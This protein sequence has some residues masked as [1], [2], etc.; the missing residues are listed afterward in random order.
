LKGARIAANDGL[1][2]RGYRVQQSRFSKVTAQ[3]MVIGISLAFIINFGP[4]AGTAC[5]PQ[6]GPAATGD[7]LKISAGEFDRYYRQRLEQERE[8]R[9][10]F[11]DTKAKAEGFP[12]QVAQ[13]M[14]GNR[15]LA[16]EAGKRGLHMSD[17]RLRGMIKYW[18]RNSMPTT[19]WDQAAYERIIQGN[20]G[21]TPSEWEDTLRREDAAAQ[22]QALLGLTSMPT[23]AQMR[24]RFNIDRTRS[25]FTAV[26]IDRS[27]FADQVVKA[28]EAEVATWAKDDKNK[29]AIAK[30]YEEQK[31]RFDTPKQVRARHILA[32]FK[33][34]NAEAQKKAKAKI[35]KA[36]AKIEAGDDFAE[37]AKAY[38]EDGASK[39]GDLGFFGP[40]RMVK[41]FEEAAF[42]LKA[43]EVSDLVTSPF[44]YHIIK[45][46]EIK[47]AAVKS[48]EDVTPELAQEL[49]KKEKTSGLTKAHAAAILAVMQSGVS[50]KKLFAAGPEGDE[51]R[52]KAG[53]ENTLKLR[54]E[55]TGWVTAKSRQIKGIGLV[56]GM[57]SGLVK[58]EKTGPC[59]S[60][61]PTETGFALCALEERETPDD[62]A[63]EETSEQLRLYLGYKLRERLLTELKANLQEAKNTQIHTQGI[64]GKRY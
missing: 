28:E 35:D 37:V 27:A 38:S 43:G 22:I 33:K 64:E 21:V 6:S 39:G 49:L 13:E 63:F 50:L 20:Y 7:G 19:G 25:R 44:G 4:Q 48:L 51:V 59:P 15:L 55:D 17:E 10:D 52:L 23:A 56:P 53:Y 16:M 46:E 5:T 18:F 2:Q 26:R 58:L 57:A 14:V 61:Y 9:K 11:D 30:A 24:D 42:A 3:L 1:L 34:G 45:V 29:S 54:T 60:V 8:R 31:S 12:Q 32:K 40:G 62:K 36:R 47:D 41:A